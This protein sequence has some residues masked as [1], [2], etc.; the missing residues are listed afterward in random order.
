ML[1]KSKMI[2][3]NTGMTALLLLLLLVLPI[4]TSAQSR[5]GRPRAADPAVQAYFEMARRSFSADGAFETVAFME[6]HWRLPGNSGFDASI[7]RVEQILVEAGYLQ[8][9][10]TGGHP[11]TY[12]IEKRPMQG[13]AWDPVDASLT[14]VGESKP[15]LQL[16][17]NWNMLASYSFPTPSEGIEAEVVYVGRGRAEDFEG[18][19]VTGKIVL[20]E[21]S[22]GRLFRAAVQQ[23]GA[24]GIL[25]YSMPAFNRPQIYRHAI[26][27]SSIGYDEEKKSWGLR[28]SLAALEHLKKGLEKG[29]VRVRVTVDSRIFPSEELTLIADVRGS[30]LPDE[31]FVFSAHVQEPGANDNASG[32]A[33]Q[34]EM[35]AAL[36]GM[37]NDGMSHPRRSITFIWGDEISS[38]ARYMRDDPERSRGV[39]WG[40]SLDMVGEN[41]SVTGGSFLI[42]KMPDPSAIWTRGEDRH[43]EWF[44][45]RRSSLSEDQLTPHYFNDFILSRCLEQAAAVRRWV[46][47]TNPYEGGSDH[48]PFLRADKPG[49]LLWHFTDYFYH[50]DADRLDKVSSATMRNVGVSALVSSL[51]LASA[52]SETAGSIVVEIKTAALKRLEA[53]YELSRVALQDGADLQEEVTILTAWK[54]WYVEAIR[55][56]VDIEV[57]GSSLQTKT[58]IDEAANNI[59]E[60]GT[61]LIEKLR[62]GAYSLFRELSRIDALE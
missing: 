47:R 27:F 55:S 50:T 35:A 42:E 3:R 19:D 29:E 1:E 51:T 8:E 15:L 43:T 46:V 11:F 14:V 5:R 2:H 49:L 40:I 17:S 10:E 21:T 32:V 58:A 28:I 24:V 34:A 4:S 36:A 45:N 25:S 52:D 48:V 62:S 44:G 39:K 41:T 12:R 57:G 9:E 13:P 60:F 53:E 61:S 59:D 56:T 54:D 30:E 18:L 7:H 38:T 16:H 31:R 37:V 20:G 22:S 26:Q 33:T 23:R 6:N